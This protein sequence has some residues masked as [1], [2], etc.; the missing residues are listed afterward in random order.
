[1]S[2]FGVINFS[3]VTQGFSPIIVP[4][5]VSEGAKAAKRLSDRLFADR[6]QF[7]QLEKAVC[8]YWVERGILSGLL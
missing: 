6:G 3:L 5:F 1:M 8:F 4:A 7:D 2:S